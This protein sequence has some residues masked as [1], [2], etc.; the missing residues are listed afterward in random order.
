MSARKVVICR[1]VVKALS[2]APGDE[3]EVQLDPLG[4]LGV[5]FA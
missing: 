1:S 5:R 2:V 3:V 4:H